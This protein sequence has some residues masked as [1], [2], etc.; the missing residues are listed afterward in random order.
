MIHGEGEGGI[1][2]VSPGEGCYRSMKPGEIRVEMSRA[3][4]QRSYQKNHKVVLIG[5]VKSLQ[6]VSM[7]RNSSVPKVWV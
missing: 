7:V 1:Y 6:K 5:T 3:K 2:Q 4:R